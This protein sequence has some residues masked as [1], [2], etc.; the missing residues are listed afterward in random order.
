LTLVLARSAPV[1]RAQASTFGR[2]LKLH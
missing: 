2:V 1:S